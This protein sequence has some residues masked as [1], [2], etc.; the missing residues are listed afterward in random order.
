MKQDII[1]RLNKIMGI[2]D[3]HII[4]ACE[5]GSRAW[6]FSSEDSDYDVRFLYAHPPEWY[7]SISVEHKRDVIEDTKDFPFDIV[8]WDIRKALKLLGKSNPQL[9]EWT[10]SPIVYMED[11][12]YKQFSLIIDRCFSQRKSM[13]HYINMS[14]HT[15]KTYLEG[16]HIL[17]K[18]YFYA[19]RPLLA[20]LYME[21]VGNNIPTDFT[22]LV[23][24]T[25]K[26]VTEADLIHAIGK[27]WDEKTSGLE[28]Q[29]G[30][31]IKVID[32]FIYE[33]TKRLEAQNFTDTKLDMT[34][35]DRTFRNILHDSYNLAAV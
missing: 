26:P 11:P 22:T 13:Y 6:G 23:H 3:V 31:R 2:H 27:L 19:I 20:C 33:E 18:K 30:P 10:R 24:T 5:S 16:S 21:R 12:G 8:G 28:K 9:I 4:Y 7:Q 34:L 17:L 15:R 25:L 14:E 1:R 32:Q 29:M 35:L